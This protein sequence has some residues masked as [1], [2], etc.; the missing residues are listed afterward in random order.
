MPKFESFLK[1]EH[2]IKSIL[3]KRFYF[4]IESIIFVRSIDGIKFYV[5]RLV[6]L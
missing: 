5:R 3:K 1:K 6:F 2:I 4:L